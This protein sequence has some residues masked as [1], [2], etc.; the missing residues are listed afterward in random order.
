MIDNFHYNYEHDRKYFT[1]YKKSSVP[2]LLMGN[3][4]FF[5]DSFPQTLYNLFF[6]CMTEGWYLTTNQTFLMFC[7][8]SPLIVYEYH[9]TS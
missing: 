1:Y 8:L 6:G 3:S 9:L 4:V 7:E 2:F 5:N